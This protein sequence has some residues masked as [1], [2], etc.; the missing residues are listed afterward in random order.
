MNST[1]ENQQAGKKVFAIALDAAEPS[2][3]EKWIEEGHLKNLASL[4][5][6]GKFGKISSTAEW[7]AGSVWPTFYT[8]VNP[9]EHGFYHY[10][11]WRS[12]KMEYE[13]PGPEWI[14]AA[15]FWRNLGE[16]YKVI[17]VDMP[18]T[19]P[20]VPFNGI[21]I[22]GWASHDGI[23]PTS[24]F[25]EEKID[26][27]TENFGKPPISNEMGGL[28]S[29]QELFNIKEELVTAT[30][31]EA[32][33]I[34]NLMNLEEWDLFL[35]CFSAAHRGG[36]KFWDISSSK[37]E[38]NNEQ[39]LI[40]NSWLR[41][42]YKECDKA[43]GKILETVP[44]DVT[45][46]VFSLHGMGV[47]TS[48]SE[49][50][51]PKMISNVVNGKQKKD[52][53]GGYIKKIRNKIPLEWRSNFKKI[54]PLKIQDKMTAYWRMGGTKWEETM[55]FSMLSDLQGYIR[56]N[57]KGREKNGIVEQGK[58]YDNL[59]NK[60]I[61]GIKT[62]KDEKTQEPI[63][64]SAEKTDL[65]FNNGTGFNNLP[66]ILVKWKI[67]PAAGYN[68]IIS[69]EYGE[70]K[71]PQPGKNPDG[72]SGNHR[73]EGFILAVGNDFQKN[74]TF[75]KRYQIIDLAPTILNLLN[76][77]KPGEMEGEIIL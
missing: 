64:E 60:I 59:C 43:V 38:V 3:I 77:E 33:L 28:Q 47:N 19:F 26:W 45:I 62:F 76:I 74:S 24:S 31:K 21:E 17:S 13:R 34:I 54:L 23:Y 18:L 11:Q 61:E 25:P 69:P 75:E 2:L 40:F 51:L 6:R 16:K 27:V 36:H 65:L 57:L 55:I 50:L 20:P 8:G 10:L 70:L 56:L 44:K 9:G 15:P 63:V 39:K 30:K 14:N 22:S 7:L 46:I 71:W 72:R 4:R 42:I 32:E 37:E 52:N 68:K 53:G 49:Y 41:D 67:K 66:D 48:L 29:L 1:P 58:E 12:D 73:F 35:C 5:C